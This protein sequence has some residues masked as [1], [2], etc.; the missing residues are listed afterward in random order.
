[1]IINSSKSEVSSAKSLALHVRL[2]IKS[3]MY[4]RK[5]NGPDKEA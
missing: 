2:S 4:A 3:L 5:K 1:M